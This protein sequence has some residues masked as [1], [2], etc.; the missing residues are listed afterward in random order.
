MPS[1]HRLTLV[2][3]WR[4]SF[5]LVSRCPDVYI[6]GAPKSGTSALFTFLAMHPKVKDEF[7]F[8]LVTRQGKSLALKAP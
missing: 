4:P 1:A 6:I 5:L 7:R 8:L 2:R 3:L